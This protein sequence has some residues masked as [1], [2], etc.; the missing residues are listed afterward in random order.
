MIAF[1]VSAKGKLVIMV[2]SQPQPLHTVEAYLVLERESEDRHEYLD[3]EV[4]LMAGESPEHGTISMNLS[5]S[6]GLQLRGTPCQAFAKDTK[7]RSGSLPRPGYPMK[8]LFSYPDL[9]VVCGDLQF[10]DQF[11]DVLLNP[12]LI[13]EV[14]SDST[15]AFDRGE[16]F[17][18][19]RTW[20]P[21][22][23]DYLLVAQDK[24]LIDHYHRVEAN[25][26]ELVSIEGLDASLHLDL[27]N[28]T[29]RLADVYDRIVF[30]AEEPE[31][32]S[33]PPSSS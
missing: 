24:P 9:L 1:R 12:A 17:R 15:E 16:K 26:W 29:L 31:L 5:V 25:R 18:R 21:T 8:G 6:I 30:P 13:V 22:L 33:E 32:E 27:L 10:H 19:Y 11:R 20:L 23:T 28:C 3:G 14:L 2:S 7:V 4:Y